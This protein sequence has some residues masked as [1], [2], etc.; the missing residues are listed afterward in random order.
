MKTE[1]IDKFLPL[2]ET[3]SYILLSLIKPLHGYALMQQVEEISDGL[4][5]IG[6]GTLYTAFSTLEKAGLIT[7]VGEEN[8]RKIYQITKKGLLV[9]KEHLRRT[10]ILV[11]FGKKLFQDG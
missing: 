6:P 5:T 1:N 3:T 2:T 10:E 7:K 8:R 11:N 9:I 4:I